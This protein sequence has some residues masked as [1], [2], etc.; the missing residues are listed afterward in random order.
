[1]RAGRIAA[2]R[3]ALVGLFGLPGDVSD[4]SFQAYAA[5][6]RVAITDKTD[7][8]GSIWRNAGDQRRPGNENDSPGWRGGNTM[9]RGAGNPAGGH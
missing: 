7:L 6:C 5:G 9:K 4:S 8:D 3:P 2:S 1:M